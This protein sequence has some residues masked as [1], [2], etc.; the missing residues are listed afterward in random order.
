MD[1]VYVCHFFLH[2]PLSTLS[3]WLKA[4]YCLDIVNGTGL[5][6]DWS[7]PLRL[8]CCSRCRYYGPFQEPKPVPCR[9]P[10]MTSTPISVGYL[11]LIFA[12]R[13]D[14]GCNRWFTG[15]G[16]ERCNSARTKRRQRS[17]CGTYSQNTRSRNTRNIRTSL[18]TPHQLHSH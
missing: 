11:R 8:R 1:L 5:V 7:S 15:H 14:S 13:K 18:L 17:H 4:G 2:R 9:G 16:Q 3:L 12:P 10:S 6:L